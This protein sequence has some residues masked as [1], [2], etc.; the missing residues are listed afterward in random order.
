MNHREYV[1]LL[2]ESLG[3]SRRYLGHD[4]AADAILH[5]IDDETTLQCLRWRILAP[6]A[7]KRQCSWQQLERN[8]RTAIRRAQQINPDRLQEMAQYPLN[9]APTV[10]EFIDI[11]SNYILRHPLEGQEAP[12]RRR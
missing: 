8:L 10:T 7:E 4:V 3:I 5:A 12:F 1:T 2:L 11:L 6:I 9:A